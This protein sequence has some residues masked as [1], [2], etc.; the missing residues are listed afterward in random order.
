MR[1]L[2]AL[3][4]A[5]LLASE[6]R[7]D[8]LTVQTCGTLPLAYRPGA[9]VSGTVDVNGN[10]CI[11]GSISAS[12]ALNATSTLPTLAAGPQSPQGS[13]AGAAYVQPVFGSASGGGTQV[14]LTHGLPVQQ[15]T[16]ASF[17]VT[18]TFFQATQPVSAVSWP[19]PTG[20]A[21]DSSLTTIDTDVKGTQPRNVAQIAGTVPAMKAS[22]TNAAT[23]DA[24][25]VVAPSPNP[26]TVC[27]SSIAINQTSSTDLVTSTNKL[28]ICAILLV[29]ATAQNL[30]LVEGTGTVCATGIAA[31]IGGTTASV[32]VAANGGFST[33]SDRAWLVTKTTADHLCLLQSAGGN[34]SG[35][36]TYV[37][38]N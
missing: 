5:L 30:S 24:S 7:A 10:T 35:V 23:T 1:L 16:G 31:L 4:L 18:G 6:A 28:H 32:A 8:S 34:V 36:I 25:L 2:A 22:G 12:S 29:S 37:D 9:V 17:A 3:L 13:L 27:T 26:S 19:L 38:H 11:S 14:D 33:P 15:Q 20:A 21:Q